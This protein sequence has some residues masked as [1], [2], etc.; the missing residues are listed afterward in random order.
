MRV[1]LNLNYHNLDVGEPPR[2]QFHLLYE[3]GWVNQQFAW[4][5]WSPA[6]GFG[7]FRLVGA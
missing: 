6:K 5:V 7:H 3:P 2:V 1:L 4:N